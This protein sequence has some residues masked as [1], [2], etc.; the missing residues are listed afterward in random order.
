MGTFIKKARK[1]MLLVEE[2]KKIAIKKIIGSLSELLPLSLE[3][4]ILDNILGNINLLDEEANGFW[5]FEAAEEEKPVLFCPSQSDYSFVIM[6]GK[7][8][9]AGDSM[10]RILFKLDALLYVLNL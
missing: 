1:L 10:C 7:L 4:H 5:R 8:V 6:G 3:E 2:V 9:E